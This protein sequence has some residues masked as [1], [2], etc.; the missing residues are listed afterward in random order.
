MSRSTPHLL[1]CVQNLG[2]NN[3][4]G[5]CFHRSIALLYDWPDAELV[6]G[7][8]RAATEEEQKRIPNASK[9]PFIHCWIERH[10]Q[11]YAPSTIERMGNELRP[12]SRE[13]YYGMNGT[14]EWGRM[15]KKRLLKVAAGTGLAAHVRYGT[16]LIEG[17]AAAHVIMRGFRIDYGITEF[18][19]M[20]PADSPETV[21]VVR[22]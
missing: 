2:T 17:E 10:G 9:V 21:R 6:I 8:F 15:D 3:G 19:S 14:E 4:K 5:M 18:G 16:K 20:V 7:K 22:F 11:V 12:M 13:A 1:G